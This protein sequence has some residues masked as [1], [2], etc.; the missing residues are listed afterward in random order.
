ML[1]IAKA[2]GELLDAMSRSTAV[3][4]E[5]TA[6]EWMEALSTLAD[7]FRADALKDEW[8][9]PSGAGSGVPA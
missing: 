9:A 4:G 2:K 5:M 1:L 8:A 6:L 3:H 7:R